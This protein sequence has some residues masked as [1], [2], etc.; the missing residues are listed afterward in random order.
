[1]KGT[2]SS[3]LAA[4][5]LLTTIPQSGAAEGNAARGQQ[6]FRACAPC[7]SLEPDRNMTGPSLSGLW[8]RKAGALG[9]FGRY[10][11]ALKNSDIDWNDKTL[12]QWIADP[13]RFVPGNQMTFP[14]VKDARQREDLL[15]YL[16]RATAPGAQVA[17]GNGGMLGMG[18]GM[19]GG[20]M[21]VA[22]CSRSR[23]SK[24]RNACNPSRIAKTATP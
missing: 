20:M 2:H 19:M 9:S 21:V 16:K 11:P 14:G 1:M 5:I 13:Q 4:L 23:V 6:I 10:S 22:R 18:G 12:D 3:A 15:A 24:L 17:Q 7:H 8:H